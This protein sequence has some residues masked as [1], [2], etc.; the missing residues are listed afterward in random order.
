M[1]TNPNEIVTALNDLL[2]QEQNLGPVQ[3]INDLMSRMARRATMRDHLKQLTN[4]SKE[5][6]QRIQHLPLLPPLDIVRWAQAVLAMSNLVFLEVDTTGLHQ[7]AEIIRLVVLN[8]GAEPLLD[9]YVKPSDLLAG[10]TIYLT[11]ITPYQIEQDGIPVQEA[12]ARLADTLEGKYVLSYNL[13]FDEE[14]LGYATKRLGISPLVII[15]DCL[16][17]QVTRYLGATSYPKLA[18]LCRQAG[19]P[20]PQR[21]HQT[22]LHRASG[23]KAI[24]HALANAQLS[25]G[26]A[27]ILA[28][29]ELNDDHPF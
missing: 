3:D 2:H 23:Q 22:A 17:Q 10:Q 1:N 29:E 25:A 18:D 27:G 7:E 16:M 19:E 5:M 9:C 4:L 11:G 26:G 20:L 13:A 14:Q 28:D 21:P 12:I 24:L 6:N 15:G 8:A